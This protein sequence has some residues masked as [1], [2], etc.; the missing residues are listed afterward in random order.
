MK[1][2]VKLYLLIVIAFNISSCSSTNPS[3]RFEG[4]R[5]DT[6]RIYIRYEFKDEAEDK[7]KSDINK[8]LISQGKNR[9]KMILDNY[10]QIKKLNADL[11]SEALNAVS[12][13]L[14]N[15]RIKN[16]KCREEYCE[17]FIDFNIRGILKLVEVNTEKI[18][19]M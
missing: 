11:R 4:I 17:A 9:A 1:I 2:Y 16:I 13:S 10:I 6:L 19:S 3:D 8:I 14:L 7:N 5:D 12:G 15:S 18:K